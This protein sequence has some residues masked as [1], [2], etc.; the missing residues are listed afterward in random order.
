[1]SKNINSQRILLTSEEKKQLMEEIQYYFETERDEKL[2]IIASESILDFFMETLGHHIYNKALDDSKL[3]YNRR[4]D[5]MEADYY[6]LYK[7]V[8]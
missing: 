4:M 7:P 1:M 5:D 3:W 8:R 6:S 2:G